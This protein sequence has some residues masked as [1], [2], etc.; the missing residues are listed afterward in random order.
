V[1]PRGDRPGFVSVYSPKETEQ[2]ET[3][4]KW[5]AKAA[6]RSKPPES[7]PLAVRIF[8]MIAIPQ[9]WSKKKRIAAIDGDLLPASRP[10]WDNYAKIVCD[11]FNEIVWNDDSQIVRALTV[12]EYGFKPG[13]IVEVYRL[14]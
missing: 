12:K 5:R 1:H 13:V 14:P 3:A 2:Y 11:A 4:L 10:D 8:V 7:G 9:S 6:M